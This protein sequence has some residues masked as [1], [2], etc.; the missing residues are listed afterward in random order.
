MFPVLL[1]PFVTIFS[2]FRPRPPA[3]ATRTTTVATLEPR[4]HS[5]PPLALVAKN[6]QKFSLV[7]K[8]IAR[9]VVALLSHSLW[10]KSI[11]K[12]LLLK[13][14]IIREFKH[15]IH[16]KFFTIWYNCNIH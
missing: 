11:E 14:K 3:K 6:S 2:L 16:E 10:R 15:A 12:A 7:A 13:K 5:Q 1:V 9:V 4:S 8:F